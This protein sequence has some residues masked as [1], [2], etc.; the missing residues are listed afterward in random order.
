MKCKLAVVVSSVLLCAALFTGCGSKDM[1]SV[2]EALD[3]YRNGD[4]KQAKQLY[5]EKVKGDSEKEQALDEGLSEA[6]EKIIADYNAGEV[7]T[8]DAQAQIEAYEAVFGKRDSLISES[9]K[10]KKIEQ[11]KKDFEKAKKLDDKGKYADAYFL[12]GQVSEYDSNY[13]YTQERL[14]ELSGLFTEQ[15]E[16]DEEEI[17]TYME[18]YEKRTQSQKRSYTTS[19]PNTNAP[20]TSS[21][22]RDSGSTSSTTPSTTAGSSNKDSYGHTKGDAFAIAEKAVKDKLKSPPTAKFCSVTEAT[23]GCS[24]NTWVVRGWVDAQNGFG[25]TIRTQ[26]AVT[27]TF[28]SKDMYS[29]DS[30]IVT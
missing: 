18:A 19:K 16:K 8:E 10:V 17:K 1:S 12:Y 9:E 22:K 5:V 7:S 27:F 20:S 21:S 11:S 15:A 24:G 29:L 23:I 14:S 6:L 4:T 28:A 3:A 25:A 2:Q 13:E 30:C 26:F